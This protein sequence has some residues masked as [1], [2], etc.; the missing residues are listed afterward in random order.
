MDAVNAQGVL[1]GDGGDGR[2]GEPAQH[3]HGLDVGL[4]PRPAPGVGAGQDQHPAFFVSPIVSG[5]AGDGLRGLGLAH[6]VTPENSFSPTMPATI[7]RMQT[8][9]TAVAGSP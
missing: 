4:N 9:R 6:A 7:S 8:A 3:G 1:N 5:A 2:G